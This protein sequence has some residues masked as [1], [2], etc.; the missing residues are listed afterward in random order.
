[1]SESPWAAPSA[2]VRGAGSTGLEPLR[3]SF[4]ID[5]GELLKER[6]RQ[7]T[8]PSLAIIFVVAILARD[9]VVTSLVAIGIMAFSFFAAWLSLRRQIKRLRQYPRSATITLSE[10]HF[11]IEDLEP[12]RSLSWSELSH[13]QE[14]ARGFRIIGK[15]SASWIPKRALRPEE[16]SLLRNWLKRKL[17]RKW[18]LRLKVMVALPLVILLCWAIYQIIVLPPPPR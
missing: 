3:L 7:L 12:E 15:R 10:S 8:K 14:E 5:A 13:Y 1:M 2:D 18:P 4:A 9:R 17:R 16:T 11:V 6:S